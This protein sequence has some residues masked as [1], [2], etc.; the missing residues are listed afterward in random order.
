VLAGAFVVAMFGLQASVNVR[1]ADP[2][3]VLVTLQ[4]VEVDGVGEVRCQELVTLVFEASAV[5]GQLGQ[6][7][8]AGGE[9]FIERCLNRS[10]SAL[11]GGLSSS[12]SCSCINLTVVYK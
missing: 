2:D 5:G 1:Q 12:W 4:R 11:V 9:P 10:C 8:R 7:L 6:R 3:P